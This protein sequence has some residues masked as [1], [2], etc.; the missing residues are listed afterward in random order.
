MEKALTLEL[1][2]A[3]T[4]PAPRRAKANHWLLCPFGITKHIPELRAHGILG[5]DFLAANRIKYVPAAMPEDS[6]MEMNTEQGQY[7]TIQCLE[8]SKTEVDYPRKQRMRKDI[9]PD[10]EPSEASSRD[11]TQY[12]SVI[13]DPVPWDKCKRMIRKRKLGKVED[14]TILCNE[15]EVLTQSDWT[16]QGPS[17]VFTIDRA[18]ILPF[19]SFLF[20]TNFTTSAD[21]PSDAVFTMRLQAEVQERTLQTPKKQAAATTVTGA[22]FVKQGE[23]LR[24][25]VTIANKSLQAVRVE[26]LQVGAI[27][28]WKPPERHENWHMEILDTERFFRINKEGKWL[29]QEITSQPT[30]KGKHLRKRPPTPYQQ[31]RKDDTSDMSYT[32]DETTKEEP[33]ETSELTA[34]QASYSFDYGEMPTDEEADAG[35]TDP[36]QEEASLPANQ[37]LEVGFKQTSG[38]LRLKKGQKKK[39]KRNSTRAM[40]GAIVKAHKSQLRPRTLKVSTTES[41]PHTLIPIGE[42]KTGVPWTRN[43]KLRGLLDT[44][45]GVTIG[46]LSYFEAL[47]TRHKELVKEFGRMSDE[48][49]DELT[50][51]GI[52][53][54]GQ[55][56]VCTHYI[57]LKTPFTDKGRE[58][59][60]RIALTA[61]L[62]CNLIFGMP[63]IIKS[64]MIINPWE[65]Y[66]YS[67]VFQATFPLQYHPPEL[68]ETP[69]SQEGLVPTFYTKE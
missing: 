16:W 37:T 44:G 14:R 38:F 57:I 59:E 54:G 19:G 34:S 17:I 24:L 28:C 3:E 9:Q 63:F 51:G 1:W 47:A 42:R 5:R 10:K 49:R 41:L 46:L 23:L 25:F 65:K 61:G 4:T 7:I 50:V 52:E 39:R 27:K 20:H 40:L 36:S 21:T 45:S 62:S 56:T 32:Q 67:P 55:G 68:R 13:T 29:S 33:D 69:P 2:W 48:D 64:K 31:G 11:S 60:L 12:G 26:D 30:L 66:A 22:M 43:A 35:S 15:P 6:T 18:D 58:V 8:P 53:K